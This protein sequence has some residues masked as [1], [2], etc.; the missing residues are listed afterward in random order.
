MRLL[1]P[2]EGRPVL[3]NPHGCVFCVRS[4]GWTGQLSHRLLVLFL[5]YTLSPGFGLWRPA[6]SLR[7]L[8]RVL[9]EVLGG[10]PKPGWLVSL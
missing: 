10:G 1:G 4:T 2:W 6:F 8:S 7:Q 5:P 3:S 9:G